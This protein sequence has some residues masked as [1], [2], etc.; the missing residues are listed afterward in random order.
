MRTAFVKCNYCGIIFEK[1]LKRINESKKLGAKFLCSKECNI[2]SRKTGKD[3]LCSNCGL[4]FYRSQKNI[5]LNNFCSSTCS[6]TYHNNLRKENG[7]Y[8]SEKYA[9]YKQKLSDMMREKYT[10]GELKLVHGINGGRKKHQDINFNCKICN[11]NL[12]VPY[13][14]RNRKT[15][16][17]KDCKVEASVGCRTYPNFRKKLCWFFNPYQNKKVLLES[18]WELDLAEFLTNNNIEWL[19]PKFIKWID[20]QGVTRRYFPDFYLPE[21]DLYLDPKNPYA[22]TLG[23]S[24]EKML[25]ISKKVNIIYG[26]LEILKQEITNLKNK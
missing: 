24:K 6:A 4:S 17:S 2:A 5:L 23:N 8:E 13:Q 22:M 9:A 7:Y 10:N 3:I 26:D 18:A 20:L 11:A 14:K 21:F 19:R 25:A 16:G 12:L 1:S 15:C